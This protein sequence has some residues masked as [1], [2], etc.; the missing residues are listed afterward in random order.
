MKSLSCKFALLLETFQA[1]LMPLN[2]IMPKVTAIVREMTIMTSYVISVGKSRAVSALFCSNY[3]DDY[4][5]KRLLM[6]SHYLK[7]CLEIWFTQFM[8]IHPLVTFRPCRIS[9]SA[10]RISTALSY[11]CPDNPYTHSRYL[12]I[13]P[14]DNTAFLF[15]LLLSHNNGGPPIGWSKRGQTK[16]PAHYLRMVNG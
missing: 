3:N 15:D 6:S 10:R 8:I 2:V 4:L 11:T 9:N 1:R 16:F 13:L 14:C 12:N 5:E 7:A